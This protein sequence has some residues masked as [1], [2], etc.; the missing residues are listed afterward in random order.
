[1]GK[2]S[3]KELQGKLR[4]YAKRYKEMKNQ[5]HEIGFIC[6][7]R[8][9]TATIPLESC[10]PFRAKVATVPVESCHFWGVARNL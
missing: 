10:H 7:F 6:I 5:M 2:Q 9:K 1:M 3:D 8:S 4:S